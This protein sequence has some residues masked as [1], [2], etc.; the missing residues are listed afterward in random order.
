MKRIIPKIQAKSGGVKVLITN[1]N[2]FVGVDDQLVK[3][4]RESIEK[5]QAGSLT[6]AYTRKK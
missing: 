5:N 2:L 3:Y 4:A 6:K 1:R